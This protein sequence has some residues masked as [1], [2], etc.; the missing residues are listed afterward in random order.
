MDIA[1]L[2]MV[3]RPLM[4]VL[5]GVPWERL[6]KSEKRERDYPLPAMALPPPRTPSPATQP[7]QEDPPMRVAPAT[8]PGQSIL[9]KP[10][11]TAADETGQVLFHLQGLA[12]GK[13]GFG[14]L[15]LDVDRL[16]RAAAGARGMGH[17]EIAERIL[18]FKEIIPNV[19]DREAA[20]AAAAEFK[21][22]VDE[23]WYL[24]QRCGLA[25]SSPI[26]YAKE[27]AA[28]VKSGD[29]TYDAAVTEMRARLQK[30]VAEAH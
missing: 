4:Q 15:R 25:A 1:R 17:P 20:A 28:R 7:T 6:R 2:F 18:H 13:P 27:L 11:C 21:P 3:S 30:Q 29:I 16:D 14:V 26:G 22:V 10:G 12:E 5:T 24:G 19:Q 8:P 23:A 9:A